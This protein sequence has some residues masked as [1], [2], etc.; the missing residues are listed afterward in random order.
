MNCDSQFMNS[1]AAHL[2]LQAGNLI[3][4]TAVWLERL[5][6]RTQDPDH[7]GEIEDVIR[8]LHEISAG[9]LRISIVL[10][11]PSA[12]RATTRYN[13]HHLSRD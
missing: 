3:D 12:A 6:R 4:E 13:F 7:A 8:T 9:V 5:R 1:T 2:L 10:N 11:D